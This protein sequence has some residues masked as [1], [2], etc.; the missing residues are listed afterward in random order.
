MN[1]SDHQRAKWRAYRELNKEKINAQTRL[2]YANN[3]DERLKREVYRDAHKSEYNAWRRE[4]SKTI[5]GR[6]FLRLWSK[7]YRQ[8]HG[9]IIA[10]RKWVSRNC[11][12]WKMRGLS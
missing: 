1:V 9:D 12:K 7:K 6:A 10:Y 2:R 11:Q 3:E 8:S 4:Y 5:K